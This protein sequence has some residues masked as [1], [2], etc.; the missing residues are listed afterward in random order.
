[1]IAREGQGMI[2]GDFVRTASVAVVAICFSLPAGADFNDKSPIN[3]T[4]DGATAQGYFKVVAEALNGLMRETYPGSAATYKPG[5]PAGGVLNISKGQ[6]DFTFTGASPEISYAL[7]GKAPFTESLKGKFSFVMLIHNHLVVHNLMTKEWADRNGIKSFADIAAKKPQMRLAVNQPA[8]LQSTLSMYVA[9]FD[10]YGVSEAEVT[11]GGSVFRSNSAGGMEAL[12][13]GKIDVYINGN[14]VPTAEV[15]D[16]A[17]GRPLQWI[18]GDPVK[19]KAAGDRWGNQTFTVSKGVYPFVTQDEHTITLWNAMLA[20][21]HVSEETVYK[22]LKA[23][24]ENRDRVRSIHPS[25][26]QFS[27][28]T[29]SRNATPLALHPGAVRFYRELG[30]LK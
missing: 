5:S 16:I 26:A 1:M 17:R 22:F 30:V 8:N 19:M 4:V 29:A 27:I 11:K 25:L 24:H 20:G 12:R 23:L 28:E 13:D 14:F 7:E 10:A 3:Y 21:A 18:S 15:A 9:I 2:F 6:S